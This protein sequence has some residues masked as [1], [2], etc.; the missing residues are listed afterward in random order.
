M[1]WLFGFLILAVSAKNTT[2]QFPFGSC[3]LKSV[4]QVD[5]AISAYKNVVWSTDILPGYFVA[6]VTKGKCDI[7]PDI[8]CGKG[9]SCLSLCEYT[10]VCVDAFH[11]PIASQS[12]RSNVTSRLNKKACT[13]LVVTNFPGVAR[14]RTPRGTS[15]NP[16]SLDV[17]SCGGVPTQ[18]RL[19]TKPLTF[20]YNDSYLLLAIP[21]HLFVSDKWEDI[22]R[23]DTNWSKVNECVFAVYLN[24]GIGAH[25]YCPIIGIKNEF[26]DRILEI[27]N[28]RRALHNVSGL[29]WNEKLASIAAEWNK[30]CLFQHS[31]YGYGENIAL[32]W[33]GAEMAASF[34]DWEVCA[35]NY[36]KP[37]YSHF[38]Q[39]VWK[40]TREIGCALA[41]GCAKNMLTCEYYPP[42]NYAGQFASNVP[43]PIKPTNCT[44]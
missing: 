36:D 19:N 5:P 40:N 30:K 8:M 11:L 21:R 25:L 22:C 15:W 27:H 14:Y 41:P 3:G 32:G 29:V 7:S 2:S 42:G 44:T 31:S 13:S 35:H 18:I 1:W 10:K 28:S 20:T 12:L 34:Y 26:S 39:V 4:V 38:T 33:A 24:S 37:T 23:A 17:N 43:R 16:L 6:N 9:V